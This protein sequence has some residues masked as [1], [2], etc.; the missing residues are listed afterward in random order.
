M[1]LFRERYELES[2]ALMQACGRL[3]TN[4]SFYSSIEMG[5]AMRNP[6]GN[7]RL[8]KY[9]D[10]V[11]WPLEKAISLISHLCHILLTL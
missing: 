7:L 6:L 11:E 5:L 10:R 2:L 4:F 9:Q 3:S 8:N 1:L